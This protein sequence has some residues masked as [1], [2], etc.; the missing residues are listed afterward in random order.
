MDEAQ[1]AISITCRTV[2][3][4]TQTLFRILQEFLRRSANKTLP[5]AEKLRPGK[6]GIKALSKQG[7]ALEKVDVD[8]GDMKMVTKALKGYGVGFAC[9]KGETGYQCF[10]KAKDAL[11]IES[12]FESV[13]QKRTDGTLESN[14]DVIQDVRMETQTP[15]QQK[16]VMQE[17]IQQ[18]RETAKAR[19]TKNTPPRQPKEHAR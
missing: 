8:Q 18:A 2:D 10:F 14:R 3:I 4:S 1:V 9:V 15:F 11:L 6:Q 17:K 7:G 19:N 13:L 5:K 16:G 12:A